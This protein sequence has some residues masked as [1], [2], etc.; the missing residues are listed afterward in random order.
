[1]APCYKPDA[2]NLFHQIGSSLKSSMQTARTLMVLKWCQMC[3][4]KRQEA[5]KSFATTLSAP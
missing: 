3:G 1:M 4:A 5:A 2:A